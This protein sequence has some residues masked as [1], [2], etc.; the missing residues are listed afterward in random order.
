MDICRNSKENA[1]NDPV[2]KEIWMR[3]PNYGNRFLCSDKHP[4]LISNYIR[5]LYSAIVDN[6]KLPKVSKDLQNIIDAFMADDIS[7]DLAVKTDELL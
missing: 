7:D 4:G 6:T 2:V 5:D 1:V 3:V